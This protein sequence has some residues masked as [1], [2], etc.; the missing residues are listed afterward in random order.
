MEDAQRYY[1]VLLTTYFQTRFSTVAGSSF[2][3][4]IRTLAPILLCKC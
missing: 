1:Y 4:I 2:R 3:N